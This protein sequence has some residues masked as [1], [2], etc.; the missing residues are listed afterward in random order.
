MMMMMMMMMMMTMISMT[1]SWPFRFN[2]AKLLHCRVTTHP[3]IALTHT[4]LFV[5]VNIH[6]VK[7]QS[8]RNTIAAYTY[9]DAKTITLV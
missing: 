8:R 2:L 6:W 5:S 4:V 9:P 3:K 1:S 7:G